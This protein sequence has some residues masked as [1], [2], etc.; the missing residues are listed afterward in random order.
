MIESAAPRPAL[1]ESAGSPTASP[2]VPVASQASFTPVPRPRGRPSHSGHRVEGV[3]VSSQLGILVTSWT[4][5]QVA[6]LGRGPA[7]TSALARGWTHWTFGSIWLAAGH[8][9]AAHLTFA[10]FH[11]RLAENQKLGAT[12]QNQIDLVL[13]LAYLPR[14]RSLIFG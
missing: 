1:A 10:L 6:D 4:S 12:G 7:Q 13:Q 3:E 8:F 9:L 2:L 5:L 11:Y 14:P